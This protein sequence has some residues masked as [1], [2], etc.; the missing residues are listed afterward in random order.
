MRIDATYRVVTPLFCGGADPSR[1]ELRL[2]S[3]KGALRFWWRALAWPRCGGNL[4]EIKI[5]EDAL[6]G[7][8]G[9]G[10]S[11][12]SLRSNVE[13]KHNSLK[14]VFGEDLDVRQGSR[15]L[16]YGVLEHGTNRRACLR[17]PFEFTVQLYG[18]DL[19]EPQLIS[20]KDALVA[21]G[22]FGGMGSRSRNGYGSLNLQTLSVDGVQQWNAPCSMDELRE[23]IG[24]NRGDGSTPTFP[25]YT[26]VSSRVRHI[27]LSRENID[28]MA[29]L[30]LIGLEILGFRQ[31]TRGNRIAFGLPRRNTR[32]A[33]FFRRAS[34]LF[35]HIH[36][37]GDSHVAVLSF[38]PARFLPKGR[39]D[40]S[41][42]GRRAAQKPEE[43][44][45]RPVHEFLDRLLDG[46]K[47]KE[48]FTV[49]EIGS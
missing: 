42:G 19:S 1:A 11:R 14:S 7:S 26:A 8:A 31:F 38:L 9:G 25:E 2:P 20:L 37:C 43:E 32:P 27:L 16:G 34:P 47:R 46:Y 12:V 23:K 3:F 28:P 41:V 18:Q 29:L 4:G 10:Q 22:T 5:Q 48:R 45:Y 24:E 15:Y 40:I 49:I 39:S 44:L 36:Q 21:L 17:A 33:S 6:F 13:H 35:I 30:D